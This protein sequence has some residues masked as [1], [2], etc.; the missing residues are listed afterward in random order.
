N[1]VLGRDSTTTPSTSI[2]SDFA[3]LLS[4]LVLITA[5][6]CGYGFTKLTVCD[7]FAASDFL[8]NRAASF[9]HQL[10]MLAALTLRGFH[11]ASFAVCQ[12]QKLSFCRKYKEDAPLISAGD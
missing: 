12:H 3:K 2:I 6:V 10:H 7:F 8:G 5:A 11:A 9:P 4:L 1:V